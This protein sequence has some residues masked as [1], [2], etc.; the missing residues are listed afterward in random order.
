MTAEQALL[1][2]HKK[3]SRVRYITQDI[4][5]LKKGTYNIWYYEPE[6]NNDLFCTKSIGKE[7]LKETSGNIIFSELELK[8]RILCI[9]DI[10]QEIPPIPEKWYIECTEENREIL[11]SWR[12]E[13][14][15]D[16]FKKESDLLM[17][18]ILLSEHPLDNSFYYANSIKSFLDSIEFI[19]HKEITL[20]QFKKYVLYKGEEK[21]ELKGNY[22]TGIIGSNKEKQEEKTIKNNLIM[23]IVESESQEFQQEKLF[24]ENDTRI[25]IEQPI[26]YSTRCWIEDRINYINQFIRKNI[27]YDLCIPI[28]WV[29]ERNE[30]VEK[31]KNL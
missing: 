26:F 31:L 10:K 3:D 8:N 21:H 11:N 17:G 29:K 15:S 13:R 23:S 22:T 7:A 27:D 14:C 16:N 12:L 6:F 18:E 24:I 20:E 1:H 9:D 5:N 2:E 28:K 25:K 19:D 30:L 4:V